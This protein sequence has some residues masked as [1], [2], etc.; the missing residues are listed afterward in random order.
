MALPPS[1]LFL[2]HFY[3]A[4]L[5]FVTRSGSRGLSPCSM[6]Y[7]YSFLSPCPLSPTVLSLSVFQN[8]WSSRW[9]V[10]SLGSWWWKF[11]SLIL[12]YSPRGK[13]KERE[14]ARVGNIFAAKLLI[15]PLSMKTLLQVG[16]LICFS[17]GSIRNKFWDTCAREKEKA[18]DR[19]A[20]LTL[21]VLPS[22][23]PLCTPKF[24]YR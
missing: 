14:R 24:N 18:E 6:L 19:C 17:K 7:F 2:R 11:C 16:S 1:S 3:G 5:V 8:S 23:T 21:A 20:C 13:T 9:S 10:W 12:R 4:R 22:K 15:S